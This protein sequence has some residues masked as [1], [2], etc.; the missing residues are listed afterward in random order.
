M[1]YSVDVVG[2]YQK[3]K[4]KYFRLSLLFSLILT[5]VLVVDALLIILSKE[6]YKVQLIIAI[7][8][9]I[10][11]SWFAIYFFVNIYR[12]VNA[13]Y[14]Y[15]KGYDSGLK[16]VEEVEVLR[17]GDELTM[18]NGLYVYPLYIRC[19]AGLDSRDKIVYSLEEVNYQEGDKLTIT[20]YQRILVKAESHS[21]TS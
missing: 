8:I 20:T 6:S 11:F 18:V 14:R 15:F 19:F 5:A 16:A 3:V 9:T 4:S 10:L 7:V 21:W 1:D 17:K 13:R 2:E 12:D